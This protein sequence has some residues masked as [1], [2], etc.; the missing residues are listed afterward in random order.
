MCKWIFNHKEMTEYNL[1]S[2]YHY[3][4]YS[5]AC[6][7]LITNSILIN[8]KMI[9]EECCFGNKCDMDYIRERIN[10]IMS[11]EVIHQAIKKVTGSNN[12]SCQ[13]DNI[14][15]HLEEYL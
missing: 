2:S 12:S 5:I 6:T 4:K 11:H 1:E 10:I 3:Y 8:L 9:K 15:Y 7:N 14:A 13:W